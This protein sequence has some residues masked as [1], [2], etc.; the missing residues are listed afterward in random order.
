MKDVQCY[1]LFGGISL[2]NHAFSF[3]FHKGSS[4]LKVDTQCFMICIIIVHL[5]FINIF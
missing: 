1:E 3:H 4:E 2:K 5:L